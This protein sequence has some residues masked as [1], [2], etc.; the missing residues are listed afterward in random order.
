[1]DAVETLELQN[2]VLFGAER[3]PDDKVIIQVACCVLDI[4]KA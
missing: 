1:M 4:M 2:T 3:G